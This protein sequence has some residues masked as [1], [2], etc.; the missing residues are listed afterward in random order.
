MKKL[1][2]IIEFKKFD[3]K[4]NEE[5]SL[6]TIARATMEL[7]AVFGGGAGAKTISLQQA[8][9]TNPANEISR[10]IL[11]ARST[12]PTED[13]TGKIS[14]EQETGHYAYYNNADIKNNLP[15][16]KQTHYLRGKKSDI[17]N[18]INGDG[19]NLQNFKFISLEEA[20]AE[21][22]SKQK[23][24]SNGNDVTDFLKIGDKKI[25]NEG[26]LTFNLDGPDEDIIV[27]G[28][29][30]WLLMRT[31][32]KQKEL[33]KIT[34]INRLEMGLK[35]VQGEFTPV[36]V[37]N[38]RTQL[39]KEGILNR[40]Y[41]S[42]ELTT[43]Y[44]DNMSSANTMAHHNHIEN[45]IG[46]SDQQIVDEVHKMI[47][48]SVSD[49]LPKTEDGKIA[50]L[51]NIN[52]E[53]ISKE[54]VNK[55]LQDFKSANEMDR[56]VIF[57]KLIS[58]IND[59][60]ISNLSN[61]VDNYLGKDALPIDKIKVNVKNLEAKTKYFAMEKNGRKHVNYTDTKK[62]EINKTINPSIK[63][64]IET[65]KPGQLKWSPKKES[66]IIKNFKNFK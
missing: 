3:Q 46:A 7:G 10:Q 61:F 20:K 41:Y 5:V 40:I 58:E 16:G 33:G 56:D 12:Q 30:L 24:D 48:L 9:N 57:K 18:A 49:F 11:I 14:K 39:L 6:E 60:Y 32:Q 66:L 15:T 29:G 36:E 37:L 55:Y 19:P 25:E 26:N 34:P 17:L 21:G 8:I 64:E 35:G 52:M 59:T 38:M 31:V 42:F 50:K 47:L 65:G 22:L 53:T 4:I 62:E 63:K 44:G 13:K 51:G 23:K 1:K 43:E 45:L 2:Y 27:S 28:N 54:T